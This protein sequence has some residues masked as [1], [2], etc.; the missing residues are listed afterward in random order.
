MIF[1]KKLSEAP[2]SHGEVPPGKASSIP[3]REDVL[4]PLQAPIG[5]LP[6]PPRSN[7]R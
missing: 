6:S 4:G 1:L 5:P 7:A 2:Q 3:H